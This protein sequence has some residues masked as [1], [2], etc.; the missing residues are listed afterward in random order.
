MSVFS[1]LFGC[2]VENMLDTRQLNMKFLF[3]VPAAFFTHH[4]KKK[5]VNLS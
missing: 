3:V 2:K 4:V 5:H 1:V